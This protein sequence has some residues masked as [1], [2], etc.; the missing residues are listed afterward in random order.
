MRATGVKE[1]VD[2][3]AVAL[4]AARGVDGVSIAE[5]AIAAGVAQGAL[6]RH[7][8]SKEELAARLFADAYHR[9]GA[10]LAE[11]AV[12][13]QPFEA[14]ITAMIAHF[15]ALYDRDP[16]LFRFMLL[17]QHELLPAIDDGGAAPVSA[18][19]AAVADA[20]AAGEIAVGV[21]EAAAVVMGIVLQT[22]LF[23]LYR[24]LD[25]PLVPRAPALARAAVT[26]VRALDD[27]R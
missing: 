2:R 4:F 1:K 10:E 18:I 14:R 22:A 9:T 20:I 7:Y 13:H 25:G 5:I 8:R 19:E 3:A 15:C 23:H 17:A 21:A 27:G 24:R 11:I 16:A 6:Y 12:A 26:A